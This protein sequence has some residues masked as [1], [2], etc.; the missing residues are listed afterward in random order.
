MRRLRQTG[1]AAGP[2]IEIH[3]SAA[4]DPTICAHCQADYGQTELPRVADLG[5]CEACRQIVYNR[6]FPGWLKLSF[7]GLLVLLAGALVRGAPY[8]RAARDLYRAEGLADQNQYAEAMPLLEGALKVA[9]GSEKAILLAAKTYLLGGS[10][11]KPSKCSNRKS[12]MRT[13]P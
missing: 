4:V 11:K 7:A 1:S 6:P 12:F 13:A 3:L 8:I 2:W 10:R 5:F 9:P